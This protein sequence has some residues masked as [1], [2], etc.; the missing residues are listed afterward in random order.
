[1]KKIKS[2]YV[3]FSILLLLYAHL[4]GAIHKQHLN[5]I[6][7]NFKF[8][9]SEQSFPEDY[10]NVFRDTFYQTICSK[11]Y[12]RLYYPDSAPQF[13]L[14]SRTNYNYNSLGQKIFTQRYGQGYENSYTLLGECVYEYLNDLISRE[15]NTTFDHHYG[16][17]HR[18]T[19]YEYD[20]QNHIKYITKRCDNAY[21][22][23]PDTTFKTVKTIFN[24]EGLIIRI[25]H[26]NGII[27]DLENIMPDEYYIYEYNENSA[28]VQWYYY[29]YNNYYE[30]Y[31]I[32][33]ARQY[34]YNNNG[35]LT[36]Y[37]SNYNQINNIYEDRSEY[38]YNIECLVDTTFYYSCSLADSVWTYNSYSVSSYDSAGNL[39]QR[40]HF[41]PDGYYSSYTQ[42][43]Y[44]VFVCNED[45][46]VAISTIP[47]IYPNPFNPQT[48]I[49]YTI[50]T[51]SSKTDDLVEISIYNLRGQKVKS[52]LKENK[53]PGN[54]QVVW[55]GDN[56]EGKSLASGIYFAKLKVGNTSHLQKMVL[57]K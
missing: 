48:T 17:F 11:T 54:Y 5:N 52:L 20:L 7:S 43:M 12:S 40:D 55:K 42:Y 13:E 2:V 18:E 46:E 19:S 51:K 6:T 27:T 4:S 3:M 41:Y 56:D 9:E 34:S 49:S 21:I 1:M 15:Y 16:E 36:S 23:P 24:D 45:A 30:E 44:Q 38:T 28:L 57:M 39:V 33:D 26:Y 53:S 29:S 50:P 35:L 14:I 8:F 47:T 22:V 10:L 32:D 25:N 31:L 37:K